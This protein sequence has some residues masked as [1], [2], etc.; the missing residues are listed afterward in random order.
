MLMSFRFTD[1]TGTASW[2]ER[3]YSLLKAQLEH[4]L[5]ETLEGYTDKPLYTVY[6]EYI[7]S[8][9]FLQGTTSSRILTILTITPRELLGGFV[10]PITISLCSIALEALVI[11]GR[12]LLPGDTGRALVS[13]NLCVLVGHLGFLI[14]GDQKI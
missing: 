9:R 13:Y 2:K 5:E 10:L 1:C 8:Q 4:Q 6:K 11:K 14:P 12:A 7:S 3:S